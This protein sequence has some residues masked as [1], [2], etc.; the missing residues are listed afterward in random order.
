[1][2]NIADI[3]KITYP[4]DQHT[5]KN[6]YIEKHNNIKNNHTLTDNDKQILS[7]YYHKIYTLG[8][9]RHSS[10]PITYATNYSYT[11]N[12]TNG[13]KIVAETRTYMN[14]NKTV[15]NE[16][17]FSVDTNGKRQ[18]LNYDDAIKQ[19]RGKYIQ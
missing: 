3:F 8:K 16:R 15:K 19:M 18:T 12:M 1:M 13:N 11:S 9:Y 6:A 4:Y 2:E 10:M 17:A 14:N 7:R 5:L